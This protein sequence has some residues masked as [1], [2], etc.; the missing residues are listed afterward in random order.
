MF[1]HTCHSARL[2]AVVW[3]PK[4]SYDACSRWQGISAGVQANGQ[5]GNKVLHYTVTWDQPRDPFHFEPQAGSFQGLGIPHG[6]SR[7][8]GRPE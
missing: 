6:R 4:V 3:Q 1:I 5:L 7:L 8:Q 2:K